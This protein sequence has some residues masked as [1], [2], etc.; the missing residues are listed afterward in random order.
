MRSAEVKF[1]KNICRNMA[2]TVDPLFRKYLIYVWVNL[3]C[4]IREFL[5][6]KFANEI[7]VLYLRLDI[8]HLIHQISE[9][10]IH[11][12]LLTI[13]KDFRFLAG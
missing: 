6:P 4:L 8:S 1:P 10:L 7:S 12:D 5:V 9:V 2:L 13:N 3:A 11:E